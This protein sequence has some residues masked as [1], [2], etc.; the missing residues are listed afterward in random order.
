[1]TANFRSDRTQFVQ[2]GEEESSVIP[3]NCSVP[4]GNVLALTLF[5]LHTD[6]LRSV[7]DCILM[8][9]ADYLAVCS[10]VPSDTTS[11]PVTLQH[12]ASWAEQ[13]SLLI[14]ESKCV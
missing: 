6:N 2:V 14:D 11:L 5:N 12:I 4:Q 10:P 7:N 13:N 8:K 3:N 1:M 9:Y